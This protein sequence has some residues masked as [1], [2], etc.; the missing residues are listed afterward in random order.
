MAASTLS[1]VKP[2]GGV[3]DAR[4]CLPETLPCKLE[5]SSLWPP[6]LRCPCNLRNSAIVRYRLPSIRRSYIIS[7]SRTLVWEKSFTTVSPKIGSPRSGPTAAGWARGSL[8]SFMYSVSKA[9]VWNRSARCSRQ[10]RPTIRSTST[11]STS[12]TGPSSAR[13]CSRYRSNWSKSS[14]TTTASFAKRPCLTAFWATL[15]LPSGVR[16][17]VEFWALARLATTWASVAMIFP[18]N[19]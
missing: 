16:G 15:A 1:R 9:S 18:P 12:P 10:D 11:D 8:S 6:A 7:R 3:P 13:I 17:P 4:P 5:T 2:E 19:L 14:P